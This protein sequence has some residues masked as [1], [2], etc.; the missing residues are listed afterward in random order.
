[1]CLQADS[2]TGQRVSAFPRAL[3]NR[4]GDICYKHSICVPMYLLLN[5]LD[6]MCSLREA[7]T[8]LGLYYNARDGDDH[9]S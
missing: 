4:R 1:M 2:W 8:S 3:H 7:S 6:G 5:R 9:Q